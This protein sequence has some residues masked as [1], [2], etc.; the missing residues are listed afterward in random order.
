VCEIFIGMDSVELAHLTRVVPNQCVELNC[1]VMPVHIDAV[2]SEAIYFICEASVLCFRGR[3]VCSP[4]RALNLCQFAWQLR[5]IGGKSKASC[6]DRGH[7]SCNLDA[8]EV[9]VCIRQ[10]IHITA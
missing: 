2:K 8:S 7:W 6:D 3:T 10:L 1:R 5:L 9:A 4:L